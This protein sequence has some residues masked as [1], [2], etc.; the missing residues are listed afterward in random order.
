MHRGL[1]IGLGAC[2]ALSACG[3]GGEGFETLPAGGS[4]PASAVPTSTAPST[5]SAPTTVAPTTTEPATTTTSLEQSAIAGL[6]E[7][8]AHAIACVGAPA[9]CD[10]ASVAMRGT[11]A[12]ERFSALISR[13][14]AEGLVGRDI[15]ASRYAIESIRIGLDEA[16]AVVVRCYVDGG[17]LVDPG[18]SPT[19]EDDIIIDD[20]VNSRR[21][22]SSILLTSDG[23]RRKDA[24]LLDE[25][26][27]E[28]RCP[29]S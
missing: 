7:I 9:A 18:S 26:L 10:P 12:Y 4:V 22:E 6:A 23:W 27:G 3:G 2:V 1:K 21:V 29:A 28:D 13:Y 11:P 25:W 14:V 8:E 5:T 20:S 19:G 15:G 16:S 24:R 17:V